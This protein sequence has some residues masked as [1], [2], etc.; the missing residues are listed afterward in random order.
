MPQQIGAHVQIYNIAKACILH[1][2][3]LLKKLNPFY[4]LQK[5]G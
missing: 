5:D 1:V 2:T 4:A 3:T